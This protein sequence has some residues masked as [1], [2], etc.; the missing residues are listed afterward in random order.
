[1]GAIGMSHNPDTEAVRTPG[2]SKQAGVVAADTHVHL[3]PGADT[4]LALSSASRNLSTALTDAGQPSGARVLFLTE[5]ARDE[6]FARLRDD[7][8]A[9]SGW[10]MRGFGGDPAALLARHEATGAKLT[11]LADM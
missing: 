8:E 6:A 11:V 1:M 2:S 7:R 3:Y 5:T 4:G 9:H 10:H